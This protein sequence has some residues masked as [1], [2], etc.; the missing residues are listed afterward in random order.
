MTMAQ[1]KQC[2]VEFSGSPSGFCADCA[3]ATRTFAEPV[4]HSASRPALQTSATRFLPGDVL[5]GRYR[6][7][8]LLAWAKSTAPTIFLS[9][10]R[11]P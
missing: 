6:I 3:G 9:I 7:V 4:T 11:W 10:N 5:V 8:A 1:C 2:G